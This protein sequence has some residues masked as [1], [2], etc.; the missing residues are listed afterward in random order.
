MSDSQATILNRMLDNID[1]SYDKSKGQFVYDILSAAAK[2]FESAYADNEKEILRKH[3][4]SSSGKYLEEIVKQYANITR[5]SA[6]YASGIVKIT[7]DVGAKFKTGDLVSI[8]SVNYAADKEYTADESGIIK[9]KVICTTLGSA[10]NTKENTIIYFPKTISG[11]KT[12]TNEEEFS[13]GYDEETDEELKKRYYEKIGD[14]ETSG[15]VAQYKAWA[16]SV[17]GVGDAK[18][19]ECW[20][21]AGT[22]KIVLIDSNREPSSEELNKAVKDYIESVRPACSG[23]LTVESS[24]S[25]TIDIN[26]KLQVNTTN[27][28]L[29]QI[30]EDIEKNLDKYLKD[31]SFKEESSIAYFAIADKIF[32]SK[33]VKN[34]VSLTINGSKD[35]ISIAD[36]QI[37]KLGSVIYG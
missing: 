15:N 25:V 30:H 10:G 1:S 33:G 28:T 5:K 3:I 26:V 4:D 29:E 36:T 6:T 37:A 14:P 20:N 16:K 19:I 34:I 13:N 11:L 12:V 27:Y 24:T 23:A 8:G 31:V 22:I 9:A 2:E 7:A 21:G 35:D 17:T 32:N 18:V